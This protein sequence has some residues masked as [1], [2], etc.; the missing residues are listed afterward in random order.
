MERIEKIFLNSI[1]HFALMQNEP[2]DQDLDEL[3]KKWKNSLNFPELAQLRSHR[4]LKQ[5]NA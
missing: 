1:V 4:M 2:K 3:A 5:G